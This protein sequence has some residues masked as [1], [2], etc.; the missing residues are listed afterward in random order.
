MNIRLRWLSSVNILLLLLNFFLMNYYFVI[1]LHKNKRFEVGLCKFV[2]KI[3]FIIF[4]RCSLFLPFSITSNKMEK[5]IS[6]FDYSTPMI[7]SYYLISSFEIFAFL[8]N[9]CSRVFKYSLIF[10]SLSI[11]N[12]CFR[13][14]L[15]RFII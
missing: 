6:F 5:L 7:F 15:F 10:L 1:I 4:L 3:F 13:T 12:R 8:N 11:F 14:S 2:R 9:M